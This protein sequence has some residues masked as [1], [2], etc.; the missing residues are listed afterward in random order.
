MVYQLISADSQRFAQLQAASCITGIFGPA[1]R[2]QALAG[3]D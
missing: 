1:A 3:F 2:K